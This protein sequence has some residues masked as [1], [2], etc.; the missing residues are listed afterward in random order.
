MDAQILLVDE[1]L[2][3]QAIGPPVDVPVDVAEVVA[4][5]VGAVVRELDALSLAR[6][7]ALAL[8]AAAERPTRRDREPLQ[9]RQELGAEYVLTSAD[10]HA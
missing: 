6:A 7:T 9:L 5:P 10:R 1:E 8:H 4:D 2:D 3:V